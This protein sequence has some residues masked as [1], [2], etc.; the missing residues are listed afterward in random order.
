MK[1]KGLT[2]WIMVLAIV[3][4]AIVATAATGCGS[5]TGTTSSDAAATP[6]ADSSLSGP[7]AMVPA[8]I[9]SSGVL[10]V[11]GEANYV[12]MES[13]DKSGNLVGLD[14]DL[15]RG[16]AKILGLKVEWV[17]TAWDGLRPAM[18]AGKFDVICS[19]LADFTD[20]QPQ[21][22]FVDYM[23][24]VEGALVLKSNAG[25]TS[26]DELAGKPVSAARGTVAVPDQVKISNQLKAKGLAP[27]VP[28]VFK[29][30]TPGIMAVANGRMFAHIMDTV[31]GAYTAQTAKNGQ[32]FAMV[33]PKLGGVDP[34]FPYGMAVTKDANGTALAKAIQAALTQ[35]VSDG[36]YHQ[37]FV[38]YGIPAT[39]LKIITINGGK[40][41]SGA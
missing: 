29:G 34:G 13:F 27:L 10:K 41:A 21:V 25:I 17:N 11:G 18:L 5:S 7:A 26:I 31:G 3:C 20:R 35:M 32:Q 14:P 23:N 37:I 12:P 1:P 24:I 22:T 39:E 6:A 4:M 40:T 33:L 30:D 16:V 19:S 8:S 38:K 36:S 9:R 28:S 2:L 15:I